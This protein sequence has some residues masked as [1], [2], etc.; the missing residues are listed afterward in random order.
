MVKAIADDITNTKTF[1][2]S[3]LAGVLNAVLNPAA[4]ATGW[5]HAL[6]GQVTQ[7]GEGVYYSTHMRVHGLHVEM[8]DLVL[9]DDACGVVLA[10]FLID[11]ILHAAVEVLAKVGDH[12][13][14]WGHWQRTG[15]H[16]MWCGVA[17]CQ[18]VAWKDAGNRLLVLR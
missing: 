15:G 11:G 8:G 16:E 6:L 17:L 10:C 4:N 7:V 3:V 14:N 2:R 5:V 18:P 12:T 9:H 13:P 1:E